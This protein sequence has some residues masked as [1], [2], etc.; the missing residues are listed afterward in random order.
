MLMSARSRSEIPATSSSETSS[1]VDASWA[2][3][4]EGR[5]SLVGQWSWW[6]LSS[7]SCAGKR[8]HAVDADCPTHRRGVTSV[9]RLGRG[10]AAARPTGT[11]LCLYVET[12]RKRLGWPAM[13][14][15]D[16]FVPVPRFLGWLVDQ[17]ESEH[18]HARPSADPAERP[19][20][21]SCARPQPTPSPCSSLAHPCMGA[22]GHHA[23]PFVAQ[24]RPG[25]PLG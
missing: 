7:S 9:K 23:V 17:E 1:V 6:V 14:S 18:V 4:G 10:L 19:G 25:R 15:S 22:A 16:G 21:A 13:Q 24:R 2:S 3:T 5:T 12:S 8:A 20:F 11:P